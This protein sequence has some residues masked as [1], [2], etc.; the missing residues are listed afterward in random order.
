M[1]KIGWKQYFR[2]SRPLERSALSAEGMHNHY[3]GLMC[4]NSCASFDSN[5]DQTLSSS[6]K[7][8]LDINL[9][10]HMRKGYLIKMISF[11]LPLEK[12][13]EQ[14]SHFHSLGQNPSYN[15]Y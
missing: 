14:T 6:C 13:L 4:S 7:H 9:S 8:F 15:F 2:G 11:G 5:N 12:S 1:S 3:N 10:I